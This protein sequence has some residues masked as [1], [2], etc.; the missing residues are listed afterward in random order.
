[1]EKEIH[2]FF[3]NIKEPLY[4]QSIFNLFLLFILLFFSA[5]ISGAEL[6]FFSL[7]R[8]QLEIEKKKNYQILLK[9]SNILKDRKKLLATI[10][11]TNNFLNIGIV[12]L[13]SSLI[14]LWIKFPKIYILGFFI[15]IKF[16]IE[17]FG[18]TF[19]L[20]IF[21][22]IIP[23]IYASKNNFWFAYFMSTPILIFNRILSPLSNFMMSIYN[24]IERLIGQKKNNI[25]SVDQLSE[26]LEITK[27]NKENDEEIK[28][29]QGIVDF[30]TIETSQ[31]M[32]PRIDMFALKHNATFKEVLKC[33]SES[34]SR[35][36][37]YRENIDD[38]EGVLFIKDLLPYINKEEYS[39]TKLIHPPFFVPE[40]KK[41]DDLLNDFKNKRIHLAIV[42]DEYG[43]TSGLVTLEDV[44]EEIVGDISDEFDEKNNNSYSIINKNRFIFD[45][46][47][48]L[49]DFY[50]IMKITDDNIFEQK[51]GDADTLGGFIMEI[52]KKF[53]RY[54]QKINFYNYD[55]IIEEVNKKRIKYIEVLKKN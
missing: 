23:K 25:F 30:G 7:D 53:P 35:I 49:I 26:A 54:K 12:I 48:P 8:K 45:G 55:F 6:A 11:I 16:L 36:P 41:L 50:R 1:M 47:I 34:Y 24:L 10:L 52:N 14:N 13:A 9:V 42:V 2:S 46:K 29:L 37:V 3:L 18:I 20:L 21:G 31:I 28:F 44:V 19:I 51:K 38:I 4:I 22:E 27:K 32:I 5:L 40:N 39:W 15:P 33:I 17:I 43:G